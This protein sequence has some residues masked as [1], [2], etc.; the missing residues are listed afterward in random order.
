[1]DWMHVIWFLIVQLL[2]YELEFRRYSS[3]K[4]LL[5]QAHRF[6]RQL[7]RKVVEGMAC[8]SIPSKPERSTENPIIGLS[9]RTLCIFDI[10]LDKNVKRICI[11]CVVVLDVVIGT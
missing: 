1:M 2:H 4:T 3:G 9:K 11:A 7:I 8:S 10:L 5:R 6:R